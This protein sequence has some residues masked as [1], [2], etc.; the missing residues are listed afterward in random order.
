MLRFAISFNFDLLLGLEGKQPWDGAKGVD[1]FG[2]AHL[3]V[4][5]VE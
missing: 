5:A 1:A 2:Q 4:K 3:F